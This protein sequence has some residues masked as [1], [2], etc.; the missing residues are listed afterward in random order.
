MGTTGWGATLKKVQAHREV[1]MTLIRNFISETPNGVNIVLS[2][3]ENFFNNNRE[4]D[5]SLGLKKDFSVGQVAELSSDQ[6]KSLLRKYNY[7]N[8]PPDW[9]PSRPLLI[10]YLAA[11]NL[12]PYSDEHNENVSAAV[13]WNRLLEIISQREASQDDRLDSASVRQI[14]ERLA[15][16]ARNTID[17]RGRLD[18]SIIQNVFKEVT[19]LSPD[20]TAQQFLLRLPGLSP[21]A[22]DDTARAFVDIEFCDAARAGD[23]SR[24]LQDPHNVNWNFLADIQS[25]TGPLC[26][27]IVAITMK[28]KSTSIRQVVNSIQKAGESGFN[29]TS[30]DLYNGL[31]RAF[32]VNVNESVTI[33]NAF[34]EELIIYPDSCTTPNFAFS[35]CIFSTLSYEI[36]EPSIL[37]P[38]F[39]NCEIGQLIGI[40]SPNDLPEKMRGLTVN[41]FVDSVSTNSD[42]LNS[43][44]P[45]G[46]KALNSCL[47]KL[48][49]QSGAGRQEA[50]FYRGS[51]P[52][53]V[54]LAMPHVLKLI[55]KYEFA[56]Q[57]K[58]RGRII[59]VPDWKMSD[60]ARRII[61]SPGSSTEPIAKEAKLL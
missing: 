30:L 48:F 1:S 47:R 21:T 42:V 34:D 10:S 14:I 29:Q 9:L 40:L 27:E 51:V 59:W 41:E 25:P 23:I 19:G 28:E 3:R 7:F 13:G 11:E 57:E 55:Q 24:F 37:T 38:Q 45:S 8:N 16:I 50:A 33:Y 61:S 44:I 4:R 12:L 15:T 32:E 56:T 39:H 36:G 35:S 53:D 6:T 43:D 22:A 31:V 20:E 17:G 60:K 58:R 46:L 5:E 49:L 26:K 18:V 54:R 2:G 52:A